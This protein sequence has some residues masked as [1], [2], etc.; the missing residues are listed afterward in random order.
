M[1]LNYYTVKNKVESELSI[2]KSRFISHV[3]P[4][5]AADQAED[6]I[7]SIKEK[8][9]EATHNVYAYLIGHQGLIQKASDDGEPSGTAGKPVLEVIKNKKLQN[10]VVVV[11]R[12][13]G[14][15]LLGAGGLIR[16][17]SQSAVQGIE[18]AIEVEKILHKKLSITVDYPHFGVLQRKIEELE[19]PL[20][21]IDYTDVV[22][23]NVFAKAIE[24][25]NIKRMFI[26]LTSGQACVTEKENKYLDFVRK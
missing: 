22:T 15:K 1:L 3:A 9:R 23:I 12:Y 4:V 24:I 6:F 16:A 11:T 21:G 13:F 5:G 2:K 14:G 17:Y 19:L 7:L 18:A 25:E 26:N 20:E 8:H 10:V